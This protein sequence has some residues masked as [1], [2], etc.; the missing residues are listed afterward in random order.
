MDVGLRFKEVEHK[1]IVPPTFDVEAFTTRVEALGPS[2]R[3]DL[4]VRDRYFITEAGRA[5]GFILRHRHDRELHELTL[6][7]VTRDAEVRDE[8]NLKLRPVDQD[9]TVDAFVRAQ[10]P[11][12]QGTLWK[13]IRVWHFP[14]CEVVYY[15]ASI[16]D[17]SRVIDCVEFEA[18][19]Q[20]TLD[21]ALTVMARFE[22]ATGF[23]DAIR[24]PASLVELMWP[25]VFAELGWRTTP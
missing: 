20:A 4:R 23:A 12:W 10:R 5:G 24:T 7:T 25:T 18:V 15:R 19:H 2:H 9:A 3:V 21:E 22:A 6:K 13:D 17:D 14:D 16:D 8:I 11:I 1:F